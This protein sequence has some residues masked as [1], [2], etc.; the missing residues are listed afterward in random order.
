M[1]QKLKLVLV[2]GGALGSVGLALVLL[3]L[4]AMGAFGGIAQGIILLTGLALAWTSVAMLARFV[5]WRY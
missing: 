2:V 4:G 1:P 3:V 5:D